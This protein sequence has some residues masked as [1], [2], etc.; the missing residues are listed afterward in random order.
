[1]AINNTVTLIG[2][3]GAEARVI[4]TDEKT[5]AGLSIAT[6]DSYKDDSDQ[7]H[8]KETVWHN[9]LVFSPSV[10]EVVKSLKTG[11]RVKVT[12]TLSYRPFEVVN[13]DGEVITKK[14]ASIIAGRV[15][16]APLAKKAK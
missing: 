12:G 9:V 2:N 15:E 10:L 11:T 3:L 14:E 8:D 16:L 5:F 1:M 13:G 4:K 7:W 6:T